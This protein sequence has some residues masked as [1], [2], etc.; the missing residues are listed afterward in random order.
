MK[1]LGARGF[2]QLGLH[3]HVPLL[4]WAKK[5]KGNNKSKEQGLVSNSNDLDSVQQNAKMGK[6]DQTDLNQP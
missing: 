2:V 4:E 1:Q 3:D 6:G 5:K